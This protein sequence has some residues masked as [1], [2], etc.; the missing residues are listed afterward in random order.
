VSRLLLIRHAEPQED[1]RG[2]CYGTLDVGLSPAGQERA[3]R[4]AAALAGSAVDVV[5]SS[6]R[7]RALETAAPIA[8]ALGLEPLVDDDLRELDFGDFEGRLYDEIA[9]SEPELYR[10][11]METPTRVQFPG[12][13]TYADLRVRAV[14]AFDRIRSRHATALVVAHGGVLRAGFAEWLRIPDEAIFRVDQ[15][16]GAVSCV[17]WIE[18]QPI[19]RFLNAAFG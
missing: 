14:R 5:Y 15:P 1:A 7:T 4:L 18:G 11:W 9:Q 10:T 19:L 6:P 16:Y 8:H 13:E 17:E 3:A 12:G 2:R